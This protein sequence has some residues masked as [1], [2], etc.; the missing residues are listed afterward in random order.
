MAWSLWAMLKVALILEGEAGVNDGFSVA[1]ELLRHFCG[2][3]SITLEV[4]V[5]GK[6]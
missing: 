3:R 1:A 5:N 2:K 6:T 4:V